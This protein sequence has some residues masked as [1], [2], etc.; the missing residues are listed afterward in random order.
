MSTRIKRRKN[1]PRKFNKR[2]QSKLAVTFIII[3]LL[4]FALNI[5]VSYIS[6]QKGDKYTK[7]VLSQQQY[8][9]T[10]IPFK[11]GNITD[12][13]GNILATSVKVY[14]LV[15]DPKIILS[16][17]KYLEPTITALT[18]CF[19]LE[20]EELLTLIQEKKDSSY[21]VL[22]NMKDL[23]YEVISNFIALQNNVKENPYIQGVWFEEQY[24]RKYPYSTLASSIIGFTYS[25]NSADWG[26]EGYYN[27]NLNGI[28]G[29][30]YGYV[31]DDNTME[32]IIKD[33]VDG[34]N[35]V[36]TIDIMIQDIVERNIA[37]YNKKIKA[38]SISVLIMN[39]NNGEILAMAND[40]IYD[41]NSPRDLTRYY[42]KKEIKAMSEDVKLEALNKIWKNECISNTFEPGSTIKPFTVAAALEEG[43]VTSSSTYVCD[44]T[45]EVGGWSISCHKADG[46]GK[47]TLQES[48]TYSCNDALMQ[49][50]LKTGASIFSSYQ[51]RF[52]FGKK[53]GID[54]YG[55]AAGILYTEAD[56]GAAT[57]ATN[58]FGQNFT[59]NMIQVA[60]GYSSLINGGDY[61]TPHVVKQI[62]NSEG[63]L[64]KNVGDLVV[65]QTVTATTSK[66]IN[67]ALRTVVTVGS[68]SKANIAGYEVGGKTGTAE[69]LP[70]GENQYVLSFIGSVPYD[71]PE[72]VCYVVIDTPEEDS[73]NSAYAATLFNNIMTEVLPYMNIF[74]STDTGKAKKGEDE[75]YD[76][77]SYIGGD[78]DIGVV[79]EEG[80]Y[81]AATDNSGAD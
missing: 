10:T 79:D 76:G 60:A 32:K 24:Q 9:S 33:A 71:S 50:G 23:E 81:G 74:K 12:R 40:E 19:D 78:P 39:P 45:E 63:G 46:H 49:I 1:N 22:D 13:N 3:V 7:Q 34:N 44:G 75:S 36:S 65:K 62:N 21:V 70:R 51:S 27:S 53:T 37:E 77:N 41:L 5:V 73:S 68:G 72:V 15:L 58:S 69:K 52:G 43:I 35:I 59:V 11:R 47:I 66:F 29:R 48:I 57:L 42:T 67:E 80:Q 20:R 28:D 31:N 64:V 61:Y 17:D 30:Q 56:M 2:M 6:F 8:S 55:E 38:Q 16:N 54:L 18:Q 4:L 26:I 25:G 14:N